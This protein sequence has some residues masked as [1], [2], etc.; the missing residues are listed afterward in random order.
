MD[1]AMFAALHR[2]RTALGLPRRAFL[3]LRAV[4]SARMTKPQYVDFTSPLLVSAAGVLLRTKST[5]VLVEEMLPTPEMLPRD[6]A[7]EAWA[8]ELLLDTLALHH[9]SRWPPPSI[10][11]RK[12]E[13]RRPETAPVVYSQPEP[14]A[15]F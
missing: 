13:I 9:R 1:S 10:P 14:L 7:G 5:L 4:G 2:W 15:H 8:V 11:F 6:A 3:R 12:R